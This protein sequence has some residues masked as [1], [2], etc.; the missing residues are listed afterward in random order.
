M[1]LTILNN[2]LTASFSLME[3]R[4]DAP[5]ARVQLLTTAQQESG[6]RY[7]IQQPNGPAHSWWQFEEKGGVQEVM[8]H[9]VTGPHLRK[10]VADLGY[11]WDRRSL[12]NLMTNNDLLAGCMA[13]LLLYIDPRPLPTT[14]QEGW[15]QYL[16]RWRPGKP[17]RETWDDYWEQASDHVWR[18][19]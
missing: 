11:A 12:Y 3:P 8:N 17:H 6:L 19:A 16:A 13:R 7:R 14:A 15:N 4:F 5:R 1:N 10:I 9:A 18:G 2:I